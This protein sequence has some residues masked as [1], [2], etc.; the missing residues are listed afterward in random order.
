MSTEYLL[1]VGFWLH[2]LVITIASHLTLLI[3][4]P[5]FFNFER[6]LFALFHM[7]DEPEDYPTL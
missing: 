5:W 7:D 2:F 4:S 3:V 1:S 6:M